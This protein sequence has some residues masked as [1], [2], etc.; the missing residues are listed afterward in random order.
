MLDF[1]YVYAV[2]TRNGEKID[3]RFVGQQI[4]AEGINEEVIKVTW[5]NL[6][7][8]YYKYA[9]L[10][11]NYYTFK[12]GRVISFFGCNLFKKNTWD[13]REWKYNDPNIVIR[14]FYRPVT[15]YSINDILNY[16]NKELAK[17]FLEQEE[18]VGEF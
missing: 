7:E 1:Y 18:K 11:F 10:C 3:E 2:T 8:V 14:Y 4:A 15:N 9:E 17:R 6:Q 12:K 16:P 13:I 5:D